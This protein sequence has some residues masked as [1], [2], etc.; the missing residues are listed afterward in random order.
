MPAARE[1]HTTITHTTRILQILYVTASHPLGSQ[2]SITQPRFTFRILPVSSQRAQSSSKCVGVVI[3]VLVGATDGLGDGESVGR[4]VGVV[5]G[6]L[7]GVYK[8]SL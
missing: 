7:V 5:V 3:G 8:P 2:L 1:H 6:V 4:T